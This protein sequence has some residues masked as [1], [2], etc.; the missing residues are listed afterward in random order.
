MCCKTGTAQ[1]IGSDHSVFVS[2][3]PMEDPKIALA[4]YVENAAGG[5]GTWAA[6]ISGLIIEKYIRGEVLR[7]D[8]ER[9]YHEARPCQKL[10]LHR[11]P[12]KKKK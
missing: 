12:K 4:V 8:V 2:F 7:K 11:I 1:N 9:Q 5:G 6:P 3:A 10:P